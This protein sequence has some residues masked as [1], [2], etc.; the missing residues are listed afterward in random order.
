MA[1]SKNDNLGSF[2]DQV[3]PEPKVVLENYLQLDQLAFI[4]STANDTTKKLINEMIDI[5][6]SSN[7][8]EEFLS[9]GE[10]IAINSLRKMNIL[11]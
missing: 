5:A 2:V 6:L 1:K 10:K 11:V 4:M 3:T 8:Q 7:K 9:L